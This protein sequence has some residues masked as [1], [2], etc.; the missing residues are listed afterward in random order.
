M[1]LV[2]AG[3]AA[4]LAAS[5]VFAQDD[6]IAALRAQLDRLQ[7]GIAPG[8][9]PRPWCEGRAHAARANPRWQALTDT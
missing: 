3:V 4:V 6:S 9:L 5:P 7:A 1:R 8:G 2:L